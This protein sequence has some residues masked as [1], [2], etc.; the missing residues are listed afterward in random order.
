MAFSKAP[1]FRQ[2][3]FHFSQVCHALSH[4]AR[5]SILRMLYKHRKCSVSTLITGMPISPA[6]VSQHLKILREM[7]IVL[8]EENY[9]TV[10]YWI[11]TDLV[12]THRAIMD[13]IKRIGKYFPQ[14]HSEEIAFVGRTQGPIRP[15]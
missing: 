10:H 6:S 14:P 4:P 13:M 7:H 2:T 5:I 8:C 9:P 15:E 11:N 12:D 1:R 3:D